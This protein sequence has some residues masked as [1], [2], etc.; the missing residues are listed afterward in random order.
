MN[1]AYLILG[2]NKGEIFKNLQ[3][4]KQLIELHSGV[5]INKSDF[6]ETAAW[7]NTNQPNFVNQVILIHTNLSAVK[8]LSKLLLIEEKLGRIRTNEKWMERTMDI[9][10]LFFNNEIINIPNLIIPHPF[11]QDRKFVLIPLDQIAGELIHPVYNKSIHT[12]LKECVDN[13]EVKF[14]NPI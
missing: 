4:A 10:I 3:T 14:I 8:L 11:I 13:L 12:L 2:G 9:D 5:I 1:K 7:G 6:Y